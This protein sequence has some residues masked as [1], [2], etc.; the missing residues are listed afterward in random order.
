MCNSLLILLWMLEELP[1]CLEGPGRS[2]T[3]GFCDLAEHLTR[4]G[5]NA[6]GG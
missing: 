1:E 5:E 2:A 6:R 4:N 3:L